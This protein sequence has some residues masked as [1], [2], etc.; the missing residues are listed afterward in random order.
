M[1]EKPQKIKL[2]HS[3][4]CKPLNECITR[5][6]FMRINVSSTVN[7][8]RKASINSGLQDYKVKYLTLQFYQLTT[9]IRK[10]CKERNNNN[11]NE[12][13]NKS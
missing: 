7:T 2:P 4:V 5:V 3:N 8:A 10:D 9:K 12:I 6:E 11:D 13:R 1:R